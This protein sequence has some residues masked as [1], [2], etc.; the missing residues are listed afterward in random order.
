MCLKKDK[1]RENLADLVFQVRNLKKILREHFV[2]AYLKISAGFYVRDSRLQSSAFS[3]F[4]TKL[5]CPFHA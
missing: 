3:D 5:K 4:V 2:Q 1:F